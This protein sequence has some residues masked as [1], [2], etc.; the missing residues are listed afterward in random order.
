MTGKEYYRYDGRGRR[1]MNWRPANGGETTLSVYSQAGQLVYQE[2]IG[3]PNSEY[4]YLAGS[5]VATRESGVPKYNHTDALG[6]PLSGVG[7]VGRRLS[8]NP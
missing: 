6:S 5:L 1:V 7:K 8:A 4:I 2:Q 3:K